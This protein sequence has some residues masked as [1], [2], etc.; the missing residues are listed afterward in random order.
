MFNV[1]YPADFTSDFYH[2]SVILCYVNCCINPF[3]YAI[4][5]EQFQQA[6]KRLFCRCWKG[7][8]VT[9]VSVTEASSR[10]SKLNADVN[11]TATEE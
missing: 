8:Q 10:I 7:N 5:Y 3:I 4:K 6:A 11:G 1:G 2:F 9:D